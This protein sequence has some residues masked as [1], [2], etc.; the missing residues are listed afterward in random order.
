MLKAIKIRL[1]PNK[2]QENTLNSLL[3]SY[4]FVFNQCLAFKKEKYETENKN[5]SLSDLGHHF[6]QT[7]RGEYEWLK[8]H[9]TKV[10]KQSIINLEQAYKNFFKQGRGFPRFK[11]KYDEQKARFPQEA[12]SSKT[13]DEL[14]SR[15][16]L[17]TT[18]K[19]IKFECS[20]RDKS[21]LYKNKSGIKS[22]TVVKNKTGNYFASILI[23]GDLLRVM[24]APVNASVG[25]DLGIKTLLTLSNGSDIA[26]PKWI[27]NNEKQLKHLHRQLSKK[28]KGSRNRYKAKLKLA[29]KHEQIKN[30]KTDFL[31]NITTKLVSENQVICMENL[32]VS[33]MLKNHKLAKAIQELSLGEMRR[34]I[35]Y[36]SQ[37]YGRDLVFVDRFY[38]SSKT[39]SDCGWKHPN[40]KLSDREFCCEGCGLVIDRDKNASINIEN[41]G[42]RIF[43]VRQR[44]PEPLEP[45]TVSAKLA[46]H[47]TK[48]NSNVLMD[49]KELCSPKK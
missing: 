7:L 3:G 4:R 45:V 5:T 29:K 21:Y 38:P 41:E 16:N 46:E 25:I 2:T 28:Q 49:D 10:L 39:C 9:N 18:I 6:H 31:H 33:G 35:E 11:S 13:F 20:D 27:R 47:P 32:N 30:Q 15:L 26:N 44:L 42:I 36:K 37:W 12:V 23:D 14:T 8:E 43:E 34:Q 19:G 1:Y 40:L 24:N 48:Q 22:V 17:T